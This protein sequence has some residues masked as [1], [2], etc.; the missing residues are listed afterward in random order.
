ME[1]TVPF[2]G[3][4]PEMDILQSG[5]MENEKLLGNKAAVVWIKKGEGQ[6]V[7]MAFSPAFRASTQGAYKLLFN[8][9]ILK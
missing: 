1:C 9:L 5:Y 2:S 6:L 7:L 8:A 4:F 3:K